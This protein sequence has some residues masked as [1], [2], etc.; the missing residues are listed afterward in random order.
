MNEVEERI[1][2]EALDLFESGV[3]QDE[4]LAQYPEQA[5]SLRLF[6]STASALSSLSTQPSLVAE[7]RSKSGFLSAAESAASQSKPAARKWTARLLAPILA[8]V[9][10]VILGGFALVG[11]SGSAMPGDALYESKLFGEEWR[12]RLTSNPETAA[13]LRE[14][15]R[16]KRLAEI[17]LLLESGR[18]AVVTMTGDLESIESPDLWTVAGIPIRLLSSTRIEGTPQIGSLLQIDGRTTAGAVSA[19]QVLVLTSPYELPIL[20]ETPAPADDLEPTP[21]IPTPTRTPAPQNTVTT[22]ADGI[23]VPS[24]EPTELA[25][26]TITP[27]VEQPSPPSPTTLPT[28]PSTNE[29]Q[30]QPTTAPIAPTPDDDD[31]DNGGDDNDNGDNDNDNGGSENDNGGSDG[32]DDGGN[33]NNEDGDG[34]S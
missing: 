22:P 31:N 29:P 25:S 5:A 14:Q 8:V 20:Q 1:L 3:S 21:V 16:L 15:F 34:G 12:L 4:I 30:P 33:S 27:P 26:P 11:A 18:E 9:A 28:P 19:D 24:A 7:Q 23:T 17:T 10:I 6:L 2:L 32:S 13:Q